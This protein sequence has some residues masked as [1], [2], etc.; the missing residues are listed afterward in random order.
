MKMAELLPIQLKS[1]IFEKEFYQY[2]EGPLQILMAPL[3][4]IRALIFKALLA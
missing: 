2:K 3:M 4:A 1:K